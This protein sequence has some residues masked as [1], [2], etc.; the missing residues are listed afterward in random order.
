MTTI[1]NFTAQGRTTRDHA[2][3]AAMSQSPRPQ[4]GLPRL[5]SSKTITERK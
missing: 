4:R 5:Y 2:L 1:P 3:G